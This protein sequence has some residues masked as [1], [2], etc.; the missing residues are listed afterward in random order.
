MFDWGIESVHV[1]ISKMNKSE[2]TPFSSPSVH[3]AD[4]EY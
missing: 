3:I 1:I 4:R 2:R